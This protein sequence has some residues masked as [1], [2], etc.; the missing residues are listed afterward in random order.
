MF[1]YTRD[2]H[3][4][5]DEAAERI[6]EELQK[7]KFGVL[8]SFNVKE[9][10][11]EKGLDFDQHYKILEVCNPVEAKKVLSENPL[12]GYFLPCKMAVYEDKG[13]VKIGMPK[14]TILISQVDSADQTLK[15]TAEDVERKMQAAID[16]V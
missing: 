11:N 4:T 14:P 10:L 5:V 2:V 15:T 12:A 8:W 6:E 9:M 1:H 3:L 7:E 16:R 13:Q